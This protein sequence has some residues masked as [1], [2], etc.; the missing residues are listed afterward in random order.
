MKKE[1]NLNNVLKDV[2]NVSIDYLNVVFTSDLIWDGDEVV[3]PRFA[4]LD[5]LGLDLVSGSFS[6]GKG[7]MDITKVFA[8]M[9]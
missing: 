5:F 6:E 2:L 4:F 9:V 8:L 3:S 7:F 1:K